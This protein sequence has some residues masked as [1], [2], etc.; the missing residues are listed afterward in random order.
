MV[1]MNRKLIQDHPHSN[2]RGG[3][4]EVSFQISGKL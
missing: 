4:K 2:K 3:V 1:A